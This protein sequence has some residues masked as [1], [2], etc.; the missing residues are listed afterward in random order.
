VDDGTANQDEFTRPMFE[1]ING[2]LLHMLPVSRNYDDRRGQQG[3]GQEGQGYR[4]YSGRPEDA[5][6]TTASPA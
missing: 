5:A 1:A 3:Q 2:M 4:L 6:V